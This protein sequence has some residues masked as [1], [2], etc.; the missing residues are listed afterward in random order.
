[1]LSI[2]QYT[3]SS[4][5]VLAPMAGITDLPFRK[6]CRQ[7]GAG[8]AVSEMVTSDTN[9]WNTRK[10]QQRLNFGD[11]EGPLSV[12][13]AGSEPEQMAQAAIANAAR[14][15]NIIDINMGCPAKKVCKKAAG[16]SLLRDETLVKDILQ[17]VTSSVSIPVTLKIRTGWDQDQRNAIAIANIAEDAGIKALA[18]HGRTRADRFNGEAEYDTI[19]SVVANSSIPILANGDIDSPEKAQYVLEHTGAAGL[20]IG[21]AA[22]GKPWLF[23]QIN[24]YLSHGSQLPQPEAAIRANTILNHIQA[25]HEFYGDYLG[26]RIA[27]KHI[28]WYMGDNSSCKALKSAFNAAENAEQQFQLLNDFFQTPLFHQEAA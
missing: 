10:S 15:A 18:I 23:Q 5:L 2:G 24:H 9:L 27:R 11:E 28:A 7:Y 22:Q 21:R 26:V 13:I 19:A 8:L 14:G 20:L 25:I 1:M 16:S 4:R 3:L 12:Q 17:A 6:L